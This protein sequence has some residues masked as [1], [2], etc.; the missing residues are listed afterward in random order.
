M[1]NERNRVAHSS[2]LVAFL[3]IFPVQQVAHRFAASGVRTLV[4][5]QR[6]GGVGAGRFFFAAIGTPV[7]ESGLA[8]LQFEFFAAGHAGF[9]RVRHFLMILALRVE[10]RE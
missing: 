6:V 7:G 10:I 4:R 3:A 1:I 5:L 2:L 8:G 9:D